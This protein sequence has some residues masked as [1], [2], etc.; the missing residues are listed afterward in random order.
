VAWPFLGEVARPFGV[1]LEL[2]VGVVAL[3]L[4]QTLVPVTGAPRGPSN[5]SLHDCV[6]VGGGV[7]G[8]GAG[9]GVPL[10][11]GAAAAGVREDQHRLKGDG[12]RAHWGSVF[13]IS[14]AD[15]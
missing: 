12:W 1:V 15:S 9:A 4:D 7:V 3:D 6:T 11:P 5:S 2:V 8:V 14:S 13:M 10:P